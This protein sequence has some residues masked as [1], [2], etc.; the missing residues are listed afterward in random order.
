MIT[1][2]ASVLLPASRRHP[3]SCHNTP[4]YSPTTEE[5]IYYNIRFDDILF[6]TDRN[7]RSALPESQRNNLKENTFQTSTIITTHTILQ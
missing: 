7:N 5:G 3:F 4:S 6:C 2:L 1:A